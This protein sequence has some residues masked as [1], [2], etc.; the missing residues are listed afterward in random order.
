MYAAV[1]VVHNCGAAMVVGGPATAWCL[2]RDGTSTPRRA[3]W[4]T[5]LGWVGQVASGA[6]FGLTSL[7]Y[8][9]ELPEIAGVARLALSVKIA[10]AV[11]AFGLAVRCGVVSLRRQTDVP[12]SLWSILFVLGL[13]AMVAAAFLRWYA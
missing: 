9:G 7:S 13:T 10:C 6:A 11:V 2:A 4:I 5:G 8:H 1:Q 12:R 3:V